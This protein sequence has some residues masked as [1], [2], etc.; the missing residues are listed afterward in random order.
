MWSLRQ[1]LTDLAQLPVT[2]PDGT[3]VSVDEQEA[4]RSVYPNGHLPEAFDPAQGIRSLFP[5]GKAARVSQLMDY[6]NSW[7]S[8]FQ[9]GSLSASA[10]ISADGTGNWCLRATVE[11]EGH[12]KFGLGFV[13]GFSTD[14]AGHGF[15]ATGDYGLELDDNTLSFGVFANGSDP[16]I[17][18]NWP[19]IFAGRTFFYIS[20]ATGYRKLPPIANAALDHGF[21]GLASLQGPKPGDTFAS[22]VIDAQEPGFEYLWGPEMIEV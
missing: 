8:A 17:R 1:A 14:A 5:G 15:V 6:L 19:S 10:N 22:V 16:W 20:E 21:N 7:D 4:G 12:G 2:Y 11:C 18:A 9:V 13:F 3:P